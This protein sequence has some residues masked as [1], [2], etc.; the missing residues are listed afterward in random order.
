MDC[1]KISRYIFLKNK[2][3]WIYYQ[4]GKY[5]LPHSFVYNFFLSLNIIRLILYFYTFVKTKKNIE[6]F[7]YFP[8]KR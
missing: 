1:L 8:S 3:K 5:I 6:Y 2:K 4:Y 7:A